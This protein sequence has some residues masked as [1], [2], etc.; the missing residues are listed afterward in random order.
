MTSRPS[1]SRSTCKRRRER[2]ELVGVVLAAGVVA[3]VALLADNATLVGIADDVLI[4]I[5]AAFEL[6]AL[7]VSMGF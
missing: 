2:P 3:I 6:A 5:I 4:P 7:R 1:R